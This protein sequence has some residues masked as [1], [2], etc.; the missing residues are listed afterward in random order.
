MIVTGNKTTHVRAT[1]LYS[2]MIRLRSQKAIVLL[3]FGG[4]IFIPWTEAGRK[5]SSKVTI[6]A[7]CADDEYQC[8]NGS[9]I[10]KAG[11]CNDSK[12][13]SDG[14]DENGCDYFLCKKP[15]WYRCKHDKSCISASFLCDKH[16]DCPLGDDEENC[17]NYEV[18]HV[19]VPCSKFEFTCT[20]K[21]CIPAD[22]VCDGE[23]H[24]L[25][26]SDETIGCMDIESKCKGFL[27]KNKHCLKSHD[28]VCDGV[29]DCGDGSDEHNCFTS[30]TVEHGKFECAD[31]SSCVDLE[32]VCD[33]KDDC[34]DRSDEGGLCKSKDCTSMRC[35]EGCKITPRGAVC[36]CK[37]G[38][39]FDKERKTCEDI[40]E[41][42]RHGLCS[43][44]CVNTPGSFRCTCVDKF[45]L[46]R[47][48]RTCELSDATEP[49]MLYTTQ[50]SIGALY[51]TSKHQYYVAKDLSQVIGVSY[52]G[53]Y[54]YW[55][56]I[57]FKTEAIER[58]QED[59][60]KRELLLT[61]GLASPEDIALDWLTGNIYFSDSG[62]MMI[63]VCSNDGFFCT[64]L[65]Q[66]SL[67][68][69]RGIALLPQN[70]TMFYSD[71]GDKAM[72]G[73]ASMDGKDKK[74]L[75]DKDIHW[76]NGLSIDWPNGRI[77]WVDAKLKKIE[78]ARLDGTQRVTVIGD[79]LKHPFSIAVFNDRIYWSDWD[80]KS[81]QSCDKFSGKD[82]KTLVHD[83]QIFDVHIYHSS[84]Q[85]SGK[86]PCVGNFCSHLCLLA[87]NNSYSCACPHGMGL[88]PDKHSC[89]ETVK[90]QY[91]LMGVGNYLVKMDIQAF[92]RHELT[93]GDAFLFFIHR[94]A[95]NSITG[96]LF[97]ADNIQKI[98]YIVEL[99]TK[100]SRKLVTT[101]IG[102]ISALAFDY[103][104]NNLYWADSERSTVEVMSLQTRHRAIVQHYLG[105]ESPVG[106]AVVPEI[107]KMF[108]ALRSPMPDLNTH[109]D[110]QDLT[111]RG[112][113]T[114]LIEEKLGGN[115]TFHFVVDRDLRSV[116][117]N[118]L[119]LSRIEFTSYEGDT[120]HLFREFLRQP[121]S[122]AIV[123]DGLFWTCLRS[124]RLYWS[125]K[126]NL[127]V[128]KKIT[129]DKPP[130]GN[131]P[132]EVVLLSSQQLQRYDHPCLRQNGGCSHICVSAG[133]YSSACVCPAG[134][135]FNTPKNNTC[136]DAIDCEFKC[137]SGECL[138]IS[139]RC[140]GNRDCA[141]GS[142][143]NG[144][145]ERERAASRVECRFD[146]FM[147]VD[148]SKCIDQKLRCDKN[149]DCED[150]SDER[151]C[152]GYDAGKGCHEN[153]HACPDGL[154]IDVNAL[155]DGFSDCADGSD[156]KDC[157]GLNNEKRNATSCGPQMFRCNSGQ[158]IPRWWEC[159]GAPDCSDGSDEHTNRSSMQ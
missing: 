81:I 144:C 84:I 7:S 21:M 32:R 108:I 11:R 25:D 141:D 74:V 82:R 54:V 45:K 142:D 103:L 140:N 69:P 115:G 101:G 31:N 155:C 75:I 41:C 18:P 3:I 27:C 37:V 147:C 19:P 76:P 60:S 66:D 1:V 98:I 125:D 16:D 47:D 93:K 8:D 80:T 73:T 156:E 127:G 85:P 49:L 121:V 30:C 38:F 139:K 62:H 117:W 114:H 109:I 77:Y 36:L 86:H 34:G 57:S 149:N 118:D 95:F 130:F 52:D 9:C 39:I 44:G 131:I 150:R 79:V 137:T 92:G 138:T 17:E 5:G 28:W 133:M 146:Q 111:G 61:S 123:G 89:R 132:D 48:G 116:Y 102:N 22:L 83:R 112:P 78:S 148:R 136:I 145:D 63:A 105:T 65:I 2:T 159:D 58:A 96:E 151:N 70:G 64:M 40:N 6:T 134:M 99:K 157:S 35:P 153:Q 104:A 12:D 42:D 113:H 43:Q 110:R 59:G 152:E 128:T 15:M 20:D 13:C 154:C 50:K 46:K 94:M 122:I 29:D 158:C 119:G 24:C 10:P 33:G 107:G 91:L 4:L 106:L 97:V 51:M 55:T 23:S 88:K 100:T 129:I 120:R 143:E 68:K 126:H 53:N 124:K 56:D 71:W 72:I 67:H 87:A 90:R 26:G 135:I 14:S